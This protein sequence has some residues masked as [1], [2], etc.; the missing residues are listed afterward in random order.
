MYRICL[1]VF[2]A[3][4]FFFFEFVSCT[5][6]LRLHFRIKAK[7]ASLIGWKHFSMFFVYVTASLVAAA[8]TLCFIIRLVE[9]I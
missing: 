2:F 6:L 1:S 4:L 8:A 3:F 5:S 7:P 9:L